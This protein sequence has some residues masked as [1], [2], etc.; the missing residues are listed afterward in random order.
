M[1]FFFSLEK[2]FERQSLMNNNGQ[3]AIASDAEI[4]LTKRQRLIA[5]PLLNSM[6]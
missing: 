6:F 3:E 4:L 5:L 2:E 1:L